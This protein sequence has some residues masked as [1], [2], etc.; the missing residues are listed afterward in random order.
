M[1]QD[2][3]DLVD[4]YHAKKIE[5]MDFSQIRKEM[6]GKGI[7]EN[8]IKSVVREIDNKILAGD[9]KKPGKLDARQLRL[10]GWALM[11]V[12]GVATLGLYLKWFDLKGYHFLAYGPV[13][14]GYLMIV[15][16]RR[17][18]KKIS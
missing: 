17:A 16:A 8:T 7:D 6:K 11:I 15:A 12:G 4:F 10:I 1:A 3:K 13:I 9:V 2:F 5:G 18:Q 14:A